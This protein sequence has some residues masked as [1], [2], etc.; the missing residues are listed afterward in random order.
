MTVYLAPGMGPC[1][2]PERKKRRRKNAV[3]SGHYILSATSKSSA[4]TPLGPI[5]SFLSGP[6][7]GPIP[8]ARYTVVVF[9]LT[10]IYKINYPK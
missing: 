10:C 6:E 2:G 9:L 7:H 5:L 1:S 8:G 4:H 3:N